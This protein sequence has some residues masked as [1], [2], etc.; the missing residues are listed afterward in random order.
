MHVTVQL[1]HAIILCIL[2]A[3]IPSCMVHRES[4]T[5]INNFGMNGHHICVEGCR[6]DSA[7]KQVQ[8][9]S[10]KIWVVILTTKCA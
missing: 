5:Q 6:D 4:F 3:W 8:Y 2:A 7:Q 1:V 9:I 10:L